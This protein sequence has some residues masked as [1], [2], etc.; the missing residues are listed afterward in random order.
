[1]NKEEQLLQKRLAELSYMAFTRGIVTFSDFL[2]LNELNIL[3][4]TPKDMFPARYE[5]YGGY[6]LSERQMV[7]FLPDALYYEY[8]YPVAVIEIS[9]VNRKF[10]E[11]LTHRDYLGALMN[12]GIERCKLG[13]IIIDGGRTLLFA[14]E[15]LAAYIT[16]ELTR[17]RHTTVQAEQCTAGAFEYVPRYEELKGTVPSIRLDMVLSVAYPL[18]RSKL[19]AYI[20]GGKVYVNG[21]LITSNGCQLK[22]ADRI[23]IRGMGRLTYEGILS[24]TKKGRYMIAVRKYI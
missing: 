3:H 18:S 4:T 6:D 8:A 5:T 20:E 24:R 10:A 17:I 7:A 11:E 21:K 19:T 16:G 13:D 12:L 9:P 14:K 22:E 15:E 2:N 23:S 1:M